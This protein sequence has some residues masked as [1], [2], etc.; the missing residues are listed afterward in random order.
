MKQEVPLVLPDQLRTFLI[1]DWD[2]IVRQRRVRTFV[3]SH[4]LNFS[5]I[6][7]FYLIG[8]NTLAS[9]GTSASFCGTDI[10]RVFENKEEKWH[11]RGGTLQRSQRV[12]QLH[13]WQPVVI[14][15]W[16][17]T[18]PWGRPKCF[19]IIWVAINEFNMSFQIWKTYQEPISKKQMS[20]VYG[21]SHLMRLFSMTT[22]LS[23]CPH[24]QIFPLYPCF[25]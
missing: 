8:L 4:S 3:L 19:I 11:A 24:L 9:K 25:V 6:W 20:E 22:Y 1:D 21:V 5:I 23:I 15:L 10:R 7:K 2:T 16:K 13:D 17:R 12:F 18:I 14:S